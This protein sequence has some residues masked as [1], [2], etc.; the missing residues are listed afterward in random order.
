MEKMSESMISLH[1][2]VEAARPAS[3]VFGS[4]QLA[5]LHNMTEKPP[6]LPYPHPAFI[7]VSMPNGTIKP[8]AIPASF[9]VTASSTP[10]GIKDI[11]S[12]PDGQAVAAATAMQL[13]N[14]G[15]LNR[16]T[17]Y[18]GPAGLYFHRM[19]KPLAEFGSAGQAAAAAAAALYWPANIL[20]SPVWRDA[21]LQCQPGKILELKPFTAITT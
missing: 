5:A 8:V 2:L 7:P 13:A 20:H 21:H 11:L 4:P 3:L 18:A 16:F 12:R 10:H 9:S 15:L 17:G 14:H 19:G 1:N 6:V